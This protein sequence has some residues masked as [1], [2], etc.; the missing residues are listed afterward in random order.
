MK[1]VKVTLRSRPISGGR[2][3]LYLD[4]YPAVRVP[5]TMKMILFRWLVRRI[6]A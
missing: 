5:E 3:T 2:R 1:R 4:Y 6:G